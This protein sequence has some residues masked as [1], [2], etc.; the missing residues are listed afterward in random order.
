MAAIGPFLPSLLKPNEREIDF[1]A[2]SAA[3]QTA[4]AI[5]EKLGSEVAAKAA[6]QEV[7]L[8]FADR[9]EDKDLQAALRVQLKKIL[10]QDPQL[11][12]EIDRILQ[13]DANVPPAGNKIEQNV[14]GDRNQTIGQVSGGH[15][16]G[17]ISGNVVIGQ[18][19][20]PVIPIPTVDSTIEQPRSV[21]TILVLAANPQGTNPL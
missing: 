18:P 7:A 13:A 5:W 16:F 1:P 3:A 20:S 10:D 2:V 19:V 11:S 14:T 21:K 8:D 15:V 4:R 9:P 12:E 6:A 17:N